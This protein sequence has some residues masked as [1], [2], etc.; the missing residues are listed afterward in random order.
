MKK[1]SKYSAHVVIFKD[2]DHFLS[3]KRVDYDA[4]MP[5][6]WCCVGGH[7]HVGEDIKVG[8]CREVKEECGLTIK[9]ENLI[10]TGVIKKKRVYFFTTTKYTGDIHLDGKEHTDYKW[11]SIKDLDKMDTTPDLKEIVFIAKQKVYNAST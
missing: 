8:A 11:C 9:P 10:D 3:L 5:E 6:K 4:W 7:T 2:K 1:D